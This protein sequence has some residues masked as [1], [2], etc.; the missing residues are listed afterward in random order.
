VRGVRADR[1]RV[2]TGSGSVTG[3]DLDA[4]DVNID[5][6][7][8]SARLGRVNARR[9]KI[10]TGSG[11]VDLELA[12]P[13]DDARIDTGSGGATLRIPPSLGATLDVDTGGGGIDTEVPVQLT[14]SERGH[15]TGRVGDGRG[16]IVI[17][18]GSGGVR[19]LGAR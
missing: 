9:L 19:I 3:G 1:L 6:G 11:S 10:D 13:V 12:G 7:S 14:K 16:R 15:L 17:D 18:T 2:D 4:R 5:T 8:G